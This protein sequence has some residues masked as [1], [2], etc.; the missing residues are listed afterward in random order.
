MVIFTLKMEQQ[1]MRESS[2]LVV[3][4]RERMQ[5]VKKY[6]E[7]LQALGLTKVEEEQKLVKRRSLQIYMELQDIKDNIMQ[8][9]GKGQVSNEGESE[10]QQCSDPSVRFLDQ[11]YEYRID[12]S[13]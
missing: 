2:V 11:S 10:G 1:M 7:E 6:L 12:L 9:S 8:L 3:D 4:S 13:N 5:R